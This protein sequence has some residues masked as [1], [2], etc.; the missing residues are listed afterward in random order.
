MNPV[1]ILTLPLPELSKKLRDGSLPPDHVYYAYVGKV[2]SKGGGP[3]SHPP[4]GWIFWGGV[5]HKV[6]TWLE[7]C[8]AVTAH[9]PVV[10][11]SVAFCEWLESW[12][13]GCHSSQC[14]LEEKRAASSICRAHTFPRC[15]EIA[16]SCCCLLFISK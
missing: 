4:W 3:A 8:S 13:S 9:E 7:C 14:G 5:Q 16:E 10:G 11:P 6:Q 1:S 15:R 12:A 2:R